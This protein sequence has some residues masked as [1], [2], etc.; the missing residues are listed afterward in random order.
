MATQPHAVPDGA[1]ATGPTNPAKAKRKRSPSVAKPAFFVIQILDDNGEPTAFD[2]RKV[3]LV[4]VER[5]AET[6]ME[7]MDN[8]KYPN[9]FYLRGIVPVARVG[10]PRATQAPQQ[11]A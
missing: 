5:N 8:A 6:V 4:A 9:A 1:T 10:Q 11:A 7:M 2:K 3:K